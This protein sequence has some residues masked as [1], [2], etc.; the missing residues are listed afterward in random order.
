MKSMPLEAAALPAPEY[1]VV[2][3]LGRSVANQRVDLAP[4]VTDLNGKTICEMW[5]GVYRGDEIYAI[6]REELRRRY[7]GVRII[8]HTAGGDIYHV[9]SNEREFAAASVPALVRQHGCDAVISSVGA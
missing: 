6:L 9:V 3:P 1:E 5:A 7:P 4:P 2:W 8:D